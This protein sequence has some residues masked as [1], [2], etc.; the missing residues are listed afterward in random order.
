M[1]PLDL[2]KE[3]MR[4]GLDET[5]L[6]ADPIRQ[7][8]RWMDE[9][10]QANLIEPNAMTLA[11]STPDG[12]PSARMVLLKGFDDRGFVLYTN[13]ESRKGREL[14]ENP[15][16]ALI[17]FWV[18]LERQVR[19]EGRV[20]RATTEESDRYFAS[21]PHGSQLGAA[22]S[23]QSVVIPGRGVLEER[24]RELEAEYAEQD[25]PRPDHW[26]GVRV[27]PASIE[28][29]QGRANRLHDRLRY[30]RDG[31]GAWIVERLSP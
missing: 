7:F 29:W 24:L 27:V 25:V 1:H 9:A 3:Y 6:D 2:R 12:H 18:E 13:Y 31:A 11:T 4:Q 5:D 14:T 10:I 19:I 26:G 23:A 20:E 30:R 15:Y 28:F 21:R 17:L 16:A 22:V 8:A